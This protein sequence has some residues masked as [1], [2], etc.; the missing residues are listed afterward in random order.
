[1][2]TSL[3]YPSVYLAPGDFYFATGPTRMSTVL[4]SCIAATMWHPERKIGAMCHF[5]LPSRRL[6][7][8]ELN[9]KYADEAFE[10][11]IREA[12]AHHTLPGDF[13]VK[14]FGGG[15]MFPQHH[16]PTS[17]TGVADMNIEAALQLAARY[18]LN[19]TAQ[20][21]GHTGHRNIIFDTWSGNVW[22]KHQPLLLRH[23]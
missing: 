13:Q 3:A 5:M 10:L 21:I 17:I 15:E 7:Y 8:A 14:L 23:P 12:Q 16:K 18:Q 20:D 2:K 9:G 6:R 1:M 22:V 11:F 4:G 19:L